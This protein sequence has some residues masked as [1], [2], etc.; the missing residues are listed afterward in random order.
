M[1]RFLIQ[2][3]LVFQRRKLEKAA[4][5]FLVCSLTMCKRR[6][7]NVQQFILHM[8]HENFNYFLR[9]YFEFFLRFTHV[10]SRLLENKRFFSLGENFMRETFY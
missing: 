1:K 3:D 10:E 8:T 4:F 2:F 7:K 6:R 9:F 5:T